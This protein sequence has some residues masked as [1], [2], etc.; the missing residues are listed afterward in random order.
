MSASNKGDLLLG[1]IA[2]REGLLT[3][4]QLYDC[5]TAQE[6]NPAR[7]IGQFMV[8][9][10]YLKQSDVDRLLELQ[11]R[12]L[13]GI[14]S[15]R[16]ALLGQILIDKGL[17]TEFQVNEC[18]RMQGRLI[19]LGIAPLPRLGEILVKR[20][21]IKRDA[22]ETALQFQNLLLYSCP[23][24]GARIDVGGSDGAAPGNYTC[25]KC[26]TEV[27]FLFA[28]MAASVHEA[29]ETTSRELGNDVPEEVRR[30][31]ALPASHFGRYIL[32]KEIG[33]GGAGIVYRAWQKEINRVVALKLL[34]HESDTA[35]GVK[36]P[37]GDAEDVKR[38]YNET[39]AL[40]ELFHPNIV[41]ILDF[42]L[43]DNHFY[44]TMKY[45]DGATVDR[46]LRDG[47]AAHTTRLV[48]RRDQIVAPPPE[49]VAGPERR[50][51]MTS[52][53]AIMR[54]IARAVHFAHERGVYH[55]DIKPSNIIIDRADGK[56]YIMDFGLAKL[57]H[58]G[59]SA[60]VIGVVMGTP[61]Y[62]PPE[63]ASG[64][65]ESVDNYSDIYSL[66]AVLYELISGCCPYFGRGAD[67]VLDKLQ[68]EPPEPLEMIAP[69][70]PDALRYV[71][72]RAMGRHKIDRYPTASE[73]ADDLQRF[74][75][76]EAP[77][78][79]TTDTKS[80]SIWDRFKQLLP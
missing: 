21:Y 60:Y 33:R 28:K 6:R 1:R 56:P 53:A 76:G 14:P 5:L 7:K 41:P 44:Y 8:A 12:A 11:G 71:V 47:L 49:K 9:R 52:V 29:L 3:R 24:C 45:I 43:V 23:E 26:G 40:A 69:S 78:V 32:V 37:Y 27:P 55:R 62:M 15:A 64:D 77:N 25:S 38:I 66:G 57:R 51:T 17:A 48:A 72:K 46:L 31:A 39:R 13:G 54:D 65:M 16:G 80:L 4:E 42:G 2:V 74:L 59:D 30:A 50:L 35:S 70:A 68:R 73:M 63:Q 22:V 67:D 18:L 36:T 20:G 19:D 61:H 79:G 58:L 75:D 10:G 34:P